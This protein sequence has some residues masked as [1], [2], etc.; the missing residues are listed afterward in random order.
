MRKLKIPFVAIFFAL[1]SQL[2]F[3]KGWVDVANFD[4]YSGWACKPG[5]PQVVA[6]HIYA[7]GQLIGAGNANLLRET[8]VKTACNS[9]SQNHGFD[10]WVNVPAS[11]MNGSN[12]EVIIYSVYADGSN[13]KIDNTPRQVNFPAL[14]GQEKPVNFGDIV[15]R[16]LT[17]SWAGPLN[18]FGHIGIWDG[19]NVIEATGTQ[20]GDDTL[21]ITPWSAYS[22]LPIRWPTVSPQTLNIR[23]SYCDKAFCE[24]YEQPNGELTTNAA[25]SGVREMAAKSAYL[26]YLIGASYTRLAT[27][28]SS[29]QGYRYST[30]KLCNPFATSCIPTIIQEKAKRGIYRC[31]TFALDAWASTSTKAGYPLM[32]QYVSSFQSQGDVDK[33][34]RQLNFLISPTRIRTPRDTYDNFQ[35]QWW[36]S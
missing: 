26:K 31:E 35:R 13:D 27:F 11:L 29:K 34:G 18:Y 23:H 30:K 12:R 22:G 7:S 14:P 2:T 25:N 5:S 20:N 17:Y 32:A 10:I 21:K 6:I 19:A 4:H 8:A 36:G 33:W 16:D 15:G 9:T 3:A 1:L 28:S 24:L